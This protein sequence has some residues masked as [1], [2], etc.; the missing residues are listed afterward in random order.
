[1]HQELERKVISQSVLTP[2]VIGRFTAGKP[3][4]TQERAFCPHQ[5]DSGQQWGADG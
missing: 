3:K 1:M 2:T 5:D 4:E